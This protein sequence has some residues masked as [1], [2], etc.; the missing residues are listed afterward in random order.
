LISIANSIVLSIHER[1]RELGLLRAVGM[2]RRQTRAAVSWEA[3]LIAMLGAVL[4]LVIGGIFGWSISVTL[5]N[6]G[7]GTFVLPVTSLIVITVLAVVGAVLASLRPAWRA[8]RL[9][10]LR[11][12]SSE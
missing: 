4:G 12:I 2:T 5:R 10:I 8:A 7:L 9:D 6:Q 1:T 3:V 11:A